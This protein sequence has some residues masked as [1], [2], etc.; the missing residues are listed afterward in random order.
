MLLSKKVQNSGRHR[1]GLKEKCNEI[2][3]PPLSLIKVIPTRWNSHAMCL[4]RI[5]ELQ[6]VLDNLCV[7]KRFDLRR[8]RFSACE[9]E[10]LE[11]LEYILE[12][13]TYS[14]HCFRLLSWPRHSSRLRSRSRRPK[15][16]LYMRLF[17]SSTGSQKSSK[18]LSWTLRSMT[19]FGT[20][21]RLLWRSSTNT[22]HL[23]IN[24]TSIGF[25]YVC[26]L[27]FLIARG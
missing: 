1:D 20:Q 19:P 27:T 24:A 9:W 5:L 6:K 15:C 18:I 10:I 14:V 22:T 25:L 3:V 16:P 2:N 12:V 23:P 8:F 11:Q 21:R 17:R 7:D 13:S 26:F 4:L